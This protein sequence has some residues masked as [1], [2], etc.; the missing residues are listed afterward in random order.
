MPG[1]RLALCSSY[2]CVLHR[3]LSHVRMLVM[4]VAVPC[5]LWKMENGSD[6]INPINLIREMEKME[7]ITFL[8]WWKD[9]EYKS[10][11]YGIPAGIVL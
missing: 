10:E 5:I 8:H 2:T 11:V 7:E 6:I 4:T 1:L 3:P 9:N